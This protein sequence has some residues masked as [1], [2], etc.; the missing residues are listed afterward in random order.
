MKVL[1]MTENPCTHTGMAK[2]GGAVA[3]CIKNAGHEVVYLCCGSKEIVQKDWP[4][5]L[6]PSEGDAWCKDIFDNVIYGERPDVVLTIG[7]P[8]FFEHLADPRACRSRMLFQW[9]GYT[10]VDGEKIG[11]GLPTFWNHIIN[12]MDRVIAYTNFGR[13]ALLKSFPDLKDKISVIYHGVNEKDFYPQSKEEKDAFRAKHNLGDKFIFLVV[14]RNQ[15]RKNWPEL[16]KAWKIIQEEAMCPGAMFWPH[17]YFYD[18]AGHNIDDLL[19]TFKLGESSSIAFFSQIARG[20]SFLNLTPVKELNNLYNA[21]NV[22]VSIGG[23]GF[24]LPVIEAMATKTPCILLNHSATGELAGKNDERA[25]TVEPSHYLT[26]KYLTE[27][28]IPDPK[29]L[30][31]IMQMVCNTPEQSERVVE[32]A[33]EF[34]LENTWERVGEK[35]K[36]FFDVLENPTKYPIILEEVTQ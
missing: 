1:V 6:I 10:A 18:P 36:G 8:W 3:T 26:G 13:D 23:E 11:G 9:V 4:F 30:A 7:D 31:R 29:E 24:G 20:D 5:K 2:V 34:A 17:T 12:A 14:A 21:A 35:W 27:R 32:K 25:I 28:P 22:L 19:A 33:Y 16:F 15:G